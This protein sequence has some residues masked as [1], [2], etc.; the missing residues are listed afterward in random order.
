MRVFDTR[1]MHMLNLDW[2]VVF[3]GSIYKW[4]ICTANHILWVDLQVVCSLVFFLTPLLNGI[5]A[6]SWKL[7]CVD[8]APIQAG[9]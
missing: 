8:M 3:Y 5:C 7:M 1:W 2:Q 6:G 4:D 9:Y